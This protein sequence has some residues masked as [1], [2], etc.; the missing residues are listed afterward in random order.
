[1]TQKKIPINAD[2]LWADLMA[3]AEI[4]A[5]PNGGVTR[6]A[7][8][9]AD[10]DAHE[11]LMARMR[12]AGLKVDVDDAF[13][14]IGTLPAK[15]PE[16]GQKA[17]IGSHLDTVPNGGKF[18]GALGVLCALECART[19]QEHHIELPWDLEI[20]SFCDE[21]GG[22]HAGT[23]GSRAMTG[24][25][26]P[27]EIQQMGPDGRPSFYQDL[28]RAGGDPDRIGNAARPA[29][30]IAFFL[31]V[32]IEQGRILES[33]RADIGVVTAIAGIQRTE[34]TAKGEAA[35][36]GTT[37]MK[38][39]KDA[40]VTAAPLFTLL[41]KWA[42]S[43]NPDMTATIG[44]VRL[45]P[46]SAN[47][48]P[49]ECRF[50]VELRSQNAGDMQAVQDLLERH[51]ARQSDW[52][53]QPLYRKDPVRLSTPLHDRITLAAL[54]EGLAVRNLP[55]GAGHDAASFAP[56]VPTGMIFVPCRGGVSHHP[57]ES[58]DQRHAAAGCQV[59]LRMLMILSSE[60]G[61]LD[62]A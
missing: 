16:S 38:L 25:L 6:I 15:K 35:H 26:A 8:S 28:E 41:P 49:G 51:A 14:V 4:G 57:D 12:D 3:L 42:A 43:R 30:D 48:V 5:D 7:L 22:H 21:E 62:P 9:D 17:L 44:Q 36:A 47:V 33:Q 55:S 50:T 39:R 61:R 40:L 2:R 11:F 27:G 46:G 20:I 24:A 53:L 37:P 45:S 1:L 60:G 59:L 10:Q 52:R 54:R 32:H 13:N 29:S 19:I 31:E 58:I 56:N 34:V 23:V 18:D